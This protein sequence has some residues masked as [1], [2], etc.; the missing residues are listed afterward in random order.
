MLRFC[1]HNWSPWKTYIWRGI[2]YGSLGFL[3]TGDTAP[4]EV[5][6]TMQARYCRKC[7]KEIHRSIP[8][9]HGASFQ[10]ERPV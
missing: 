4:R 5:S 8:E 7:G 10:S 1:W 6:K 3:I 2:Q 9:A